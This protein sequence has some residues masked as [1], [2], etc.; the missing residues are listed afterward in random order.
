MNIQRK[1]L[2]AAWRVSLLLCELACQYFSEN[3][4]CVCE[5]NVRPN[6]NAGSN[7]IAPVSSIM[8][9]A[10]EWRIGAATI[11][12]KSLFTRMSM[13]SYASLKYVVF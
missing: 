6:H 3:G 1:A 10:C 11:G 7:D 4:D 2:L 13:Y 8:C 9:S 12:K 5:C